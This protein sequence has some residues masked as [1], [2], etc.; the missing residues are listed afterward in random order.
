MPDKTRIIA[1]GSALL[2]EGFALVGLETWPDAEPA[3]VEALIDELLRERQPAVVL[4]ESDLMREAGSALAGAA[5]GS[6]RILITEIPS[7][8]APQEDRPAVERLVAEM[9]GPGALTREES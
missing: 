6:E 5:R 9:L 2:M 1:M 8:Q 7:L 3:D 4:L